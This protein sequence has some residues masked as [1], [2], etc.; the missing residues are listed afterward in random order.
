MPYR[1]VGEVIEFVHVG[2]TG[3]RP[4]VT[5]HY[6]SIVKPCGCGV[7]LV[8]PLLITPWTAG[9]EVVK[10]ERR[11]VWPPPELDDEGAVVPGTG[12]EL[13][14]Y[15]ATRT[16]TA[17]KDAFDADG[18]PLVAASTAWAPHTPGDLDRLTDKQI[19][20]LADKVHCCRV[21]D[22]GDAS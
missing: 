14:W 9:E 2:A 18:S 1:I 22:P 19:I 13:E 7:P 12:E 5:T 21:L 4:T 17:S 3:E 6:E 16:H 8:V 11:E 20:A 15:I 10:G